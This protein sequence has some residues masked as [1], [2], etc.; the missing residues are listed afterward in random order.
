MVKEVKWISSLTQKTKINL[1]KIKD[2][3]I[4]KN[5]INQK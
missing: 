5:I 4:K 3:N 2:Q 1:K